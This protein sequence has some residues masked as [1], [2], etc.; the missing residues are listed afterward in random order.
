MQGIDMG[1]AACHFQ[2]SAQEHGIGGRFNLNAAPALTLSAN[3]IYKYSWIPDEP[4][5]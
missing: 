4:T 5:R 3:T 2:L 1:I